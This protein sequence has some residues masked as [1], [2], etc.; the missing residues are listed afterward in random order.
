MVIVLGVMGVVC[1]VLAIRFVRVIFAVR[2]L[3]RQIEELGGA[4]IWRLACNTVRETY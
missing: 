2:S 4:A 3:S 1:V